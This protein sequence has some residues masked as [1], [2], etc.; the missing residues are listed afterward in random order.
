MPRRQ[1][2]KKWIDVLSLSWGVG[3]GISTVSG[4]GNNREASEPSISEVFHR[5]D[6]R[7]VFAQ[8]LHGGLHGQHRQ[9][10]DRSTPHHRQPGA[11]YCTYTLTNALISSYSVSS[12]GDRPTESISISFT[13]LEFKFTPTTTRTRPAHRS[14]LSY[15]LAT[16]KS[17]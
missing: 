15:D 3:R 11:T 1:D 16:T 12:G 10:R 13:K 7:C 8:A 17:S 14:P 9:D 4:S 5:Q 6:V 2:H